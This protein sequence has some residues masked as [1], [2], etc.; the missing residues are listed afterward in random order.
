M[1]TLVGISVSA[2]IPD[3]RSPGTGLYDNLQKY[4]L[5]SPQSIFELSYFREVDL[6]ATF[7]FLTVPALFRGPS[8]A[9][10]PASHLL[11]TIIMTRSC[12]N[13]FLRQH[14]CSC[15]CQ[16]T[17]GA[18]CCF[19]AQFSFPPAASRCFLPF[20]ERVMARQFCPNASS[21]FYR[22]AASQG[23]A[24]V[25][26]GVFPGSSWRIPDPPRSS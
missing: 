14:R 19:Q 24:Q 20:G 26:R 16:V 10:P 22:S 9:L 15:K 6:L 23:L 13:S 17:C 2:G 4:D 11:F 3:F 25:S 7:S 12:M 5:P 1:H 18:Q 8:P 21:S